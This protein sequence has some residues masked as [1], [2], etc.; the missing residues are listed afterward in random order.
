MVKITES[1]NGMKE[2]VQQEGG[3]AFSITVK[4]SNI[5]N[6]LVT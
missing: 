4:A 5:T 2:L 1:K 3:K 6:L